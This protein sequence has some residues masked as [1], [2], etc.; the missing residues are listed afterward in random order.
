[1]VDMGR[2]VLLVVIWGVGELVSWGSG[3]LVIWGSGDLV[4]WGSGELG[5][6]RTLKSLKLQIPESDQKNLPRE[7]YCRRR[8]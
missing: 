1:M 2:A 7:A 3:E 8:W 6:Q 5:M 4:I